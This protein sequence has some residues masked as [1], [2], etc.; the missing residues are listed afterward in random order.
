MKNDNTKERPVANQ[1][2]LNSFFNCKHN[3]QLKLIT[4]QYACWK[5][6]ANKRT[7]NG[8]WGLMTKMGSAIQ[9]ANT[10]LD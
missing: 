9:D 7:N 3:R 5:M 4:N 6:F 2:H 10:G 1:Q 8:E